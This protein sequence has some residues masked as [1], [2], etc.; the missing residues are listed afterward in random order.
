MLPET[1]DTR[2]NPKSEGSVLELSTSVVAAIQ[3]CRTFSVPKASYVLRRMKVF[4]GWLRSNFNFLLCD[5]RIAFILSLYPVYMSINALSSTVLLQYVSKRYS[6]TLGNAS[7]F[8]SFE[9]V[10]NIILLLYVLPA[11]STYLVENGGYSVLARDVLLIR[12]SYSILA[13][14]LLMVGLTTTLPAMTVG[15]FVLN[16]GTGGNLM[17]RLLLTYFV[18]PKDI[19]K[20]YSIISILETGSTAISDPL[21]ASL[22]NAGLGRGGSAW[23]GLPFLVFSA[24]FAIATVG[25]WV[26]Q[27]NSESGE[28]E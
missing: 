12:L 7:Y 10:I 13:V 20:M 25:L 3:I 27:L 2:T 11:I 6:I 15:V 9:A 8:W 26:A 22:F 24:L 5:W 17:M 4:L 1:L 21:T 23:L 28:S 19:V 18:Q 14:G 16:C